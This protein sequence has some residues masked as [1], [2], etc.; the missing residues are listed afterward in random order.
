MKVDKFLPRVIGR[1]QNASIAAAEP[2][3]ITE[4]ALPKHLPIKVTEV[5][6]RL[7]EGGAFVKFSYEP[8]VQLPEIEKTV[9]KY[10][11]E[12]PIKPWFNPFRRVKTSIVQGRPW[13]E[14]L[15]RTPSPKLK[16]E[17]IPVSPEQEAAELGQESLYS[18]FRKYGK[19]ADIVPQPTSNKDLPKFAHLKFFQ[20]RKAIMAKNCMHGYT[21]P[22]D[23]GGGHAGTILKLAYEQ[24][25]KS[26]WF[27]DWI[28]NHP[29]LF[30]PVLALLATGISIAIFDP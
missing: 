30:F 1:A 18:L 13:L 24:K 27:K 17:F 19:L 3:A 4:R 15:Y 9:K 12:N 16:V 8:S 22:Y 28:V 23:E 7:R 5:L 2:E 29:R 10:L 25:A 11:K 26:H 6:P 14:D 20:K 21:V